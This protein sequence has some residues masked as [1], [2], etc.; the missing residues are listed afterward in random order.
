GAT[1]LE[2]R[3]EVLVDRRPTRQSWNRNV[4][5]VRDLGVR[6]S[7]GAE[8]LRLINVLRSVLRP[9]TP[10]RNGKTSTTK[11]GQPPILPG[12]RLLRSQRSLLGRPDSHQIPLP[13]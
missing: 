7:N 9:F 13:S 11:V 1:L 4:E 10:R 6:R 12:S 2:G 8:L 3:T 5:E